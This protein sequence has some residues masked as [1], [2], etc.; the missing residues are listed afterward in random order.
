MD[1]VLQGIRW[2]PDSPGHNGETVVKTL[3]RHNNKAIFFIIQAPSPV[4]FVI[5]Y[6]LNH[7]KV[8]GHILNE[9]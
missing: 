6:E 5:R 8:R 4:P 9:D 2:T 7:F 3:S 1:F